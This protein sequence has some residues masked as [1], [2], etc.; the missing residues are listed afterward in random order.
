[1]QA[2]VSDSGP[3]DL[4]RLGNDGA[5]KKVVRRFLGGT[6]ESEREALVKKA[7]P[8]FL[9]KDNLPPFL[10]LYGVDDELVPI[11]S[12]DNFVAELGRARLRDVSYYRL[13]KVG[14][15]PH[16]LIRVPF[17]KTVVRDFFLRTLIPS[18]WEP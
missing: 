4:L 13:A 6:P 2:V 9:I 10:L 12:A 15:C 1:V 18:D 11:E 17:L 7:S 3:I 16:S 14:H 8:A 5:L